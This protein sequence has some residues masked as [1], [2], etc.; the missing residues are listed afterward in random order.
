MHLVMWGF[1][2]AI[3]GLL[4]VGLVLL[5]RQR[6]GSPSEAATSGSAAEVD[7]RSP[8]REEPPNPSK[9]R[10]GPEELALLDE[11]ERIL[12]KLVASD[13]DTYQKD[14]PELTGFSKAKVSRLLDKLEHKGLVQRV[15]HGMTNRVV[16]APATRS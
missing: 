10:L 11:G 6:Q 4:T 13:D 5:L 14:L 16:L 15:S 7:P 1:W 12:Y 8:A 2:V 3:L 9:R